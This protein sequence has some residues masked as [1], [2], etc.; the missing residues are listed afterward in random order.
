SK[1]G[2]NFDWVATGSPCG[3]AACTGMPGG[4]ALVAVKYT[5]NAAEVGKVMDFLGREDIMREFTER[6]L[7]L[8]AHKGV[9]AGK[10]D[11]KTDDEN[12]KASL[13]AFLK[14][15]GKIAPN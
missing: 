11:Y 5:K 1:I 9:L 15:S 3:T 8:P 4:A 6:T 10:I 7:F 14:A 2:K 12:V 13:E